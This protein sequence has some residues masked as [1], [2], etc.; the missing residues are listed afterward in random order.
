MARCFTLIALTLLL[1]ACGLGRQRGASNGM[2]LAQSVPATT[3]L[4]AVT[5]AS[6]T[7]TPSSSP[8]L[9]D[10]GSLVVAA[11]GIA[12][13]E[14]RAAASLLQLAPGDL[15]QLPP[16]MNWGAQPGVYLN[17]T[18][19]LA[20]A[21]RPSGQQLYLRLLFGDG[22]RAARVDDRTYRVV[23]AGDA[24]LFAND[25]QIGTGGSARDHRV[26]IDQAG[27]LWL[28]PAPVPGDEVVIYDTGQGLDVR[29]MTVLG[30]LQPAQQYPLG[31]FF[32]TVCAADSCGF[33]YRTGQVV[34][35]VA[36]TLRCRDGAELDFD[37]GS[38]TLQF[39][40]TDLVRKNWPNGQASPTP[41]AC[42][43][44]RIVQAGDVIADGFTHY[45]VHAVSDGGEPLSV[46]VAYDGTIYA[47]RLTVPPLDGPG[48]AT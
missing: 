3:P 41:A 24:L 28:D 1:A 21:G 22:A 38:V 16:G 39:R 35:P 7:A 15:I 45:L 29:G 17:P 46:V 33:T 6:P 34:A 27:H 13:V 47:G 9:Q 23:A 19:A 44:S 10:L 32:F 4:A 20:F 25:E 31:G 8:G 37:T 36:G 42:S 30:R 12:Q 18:Y 5:T 14:N 48:R 2:P 11:A 43:G 40:D 26:Q